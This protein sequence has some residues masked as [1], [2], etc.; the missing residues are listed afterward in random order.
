MRTGV[1]GQGSGAGG[2]G[3][4]EARRFATGY[5]GGSERD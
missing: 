3:V 4:E 1:R 5:H 2:R